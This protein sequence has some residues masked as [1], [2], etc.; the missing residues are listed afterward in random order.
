MSLTHLSGSIG[1][2]DMRKTLGSAQAVPSI[3][4]TV[5]KHR[6][7]LDAHAD[8]PIPEPL[9][10]S[11]PGGRATQDRALAAAA[12]RR[13]PAGRIAPASSPLVC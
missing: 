2:D 7:L 9:R 1:V 3:Q 8:S 12:D 4:S 13:G 10:L 5:A 11:R 6:W